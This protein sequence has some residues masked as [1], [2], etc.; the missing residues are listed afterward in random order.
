MV[1]I[2]YACYACTAQYK[3][4]FSQKFVIQLQNIT[5]TLFS[6]MY[7]IVCYWNIILRLKTQ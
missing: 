5:L 4:M 1:K 6:L 7:A 2:A 3:Y